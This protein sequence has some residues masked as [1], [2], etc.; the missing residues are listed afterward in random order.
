MLSR[1]C[2]FCERMW[3]SILFPEPMWNSWV[4]W[5]VLK[6]SDEEEDTGW[7]VS[8]TW[9]ATV[10][11]YDTKK[12]DA[13]HL[14]SVSSGRRTHEHVCTHKCTFNWDQGKDFFIIL[15]KQSTHILNTQGKEWTVMFWKWNGLLWPMCW[16]DYSEV[17]ALVTKVGLFLR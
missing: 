7:A 14:T 17:I 11:D 3:T 6:S 12:N 13:Q 15:I 1:W 9:G 10:R 4:R 8:S 16:Y 5:H 2:P